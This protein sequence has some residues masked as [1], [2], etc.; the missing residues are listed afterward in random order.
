MDHLDTLRTNGGL[1]ADAVRTAGLEVP[2]EHCPGWTTGRLLGHTAKILQ[3]TAMCVR[4]GSTDAP[5]DSESLPR[6]DALFDTFDRILADVCDALAATDPDAPAWNF[7][8][9]DLVVSFWSRRM[10]HEIEIHRWD[11]EHAAGVASTPFAPDSAVDGID[12]LLTVLMPILSATKRPDLSASFHLHATDAPGEWLTTFVAG[13]Q[14]TVR[15]HAK[16]DLAVRGP[17]SSLYLWAWNR[18]AIGADGLDT[19]GD[20]SLLD[21]WRTVVP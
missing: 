20:A 4:S 14:S 6:D 15:E 18:A 7:T 10:A 12:E 17:A 1:L 11:M 9:G 16:G 8:G 13:E 2:V 19:A 21:A 5:G 3:R